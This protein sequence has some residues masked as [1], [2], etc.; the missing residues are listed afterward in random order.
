VAPGLTLELV[1][2]ELLEVVCCW[3]TEVVCD[4]D[5]VADDTDEEVEEKKAASE[6]IAVTYPGTNE[7]EVPF[8]VLHC[9]VPS[10]PHHQY[11]GPSVVPLF[12]QRHGTRFAHSAVAGFRNKISLIHHF[13]NSSK[14]LGRK[15]LLSSQYVRHP[16]E[17]HSLI[18]A[19]RYIPNVP[20]HNPDERHASFSLQ[21]LPTDIELL[22]QG[23][24]LCATLPSFHYHQVR[25]SLSYLMS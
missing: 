17:D 7:R 15:P 20:K 6:I 5:N 21:Q 8:V 10:A 22:T 19:P 14:E 13:W 12:G 18:H 4:G 25:L 11:F 2:C 16:D 23:W 1:C 9:S 24:K 3:E